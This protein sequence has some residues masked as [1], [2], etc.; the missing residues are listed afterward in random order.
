MD[1]LIGRTQ[2]V[3]HQQL[4]EQRLQ[5]KQILEQQKKEQ[6]EIDRIPVLKQKHFDYGDIQN[7]HS[8][9]EDRHDRK[10]TVDSHNNLKSFHDSLQ[11]YSSG[12]HDLQPLVPVQQNIPCYK[13]ITDQKEVQLQELCGLVTHQEQGNDLALHVQTP[14]DTNNFSEEPEQQYSPTTDKV[15]QNDIPISDSIVHDSRVTV[16]HCTSPQSSSNGYTDHDDQLPSVSDASS[17]QQTCPLPVKVNII[18]PESLCLPIKRNVSY[19]RGPRDMSQ[20]NYDCEWHTCT[21]FF[22]DYKKY[23]NHVKSHIDELSKY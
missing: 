4:Q 8:Y 20:L 10:V 2:K 17:T 15:E 9:S 19:A 3:E 5:L 22:S 14:V 21:C 18:G 6:E 16:L 11:D 12:R 7:V 13:D 1:N 23:L